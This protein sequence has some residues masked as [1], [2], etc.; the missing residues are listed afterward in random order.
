MSKEETPNTASSQMVFSPSHSSHASHN[1]T[2]LSSTSTVDYPSSNLMSTPNTDGGRLLGAH[3]IGGHDGS[4]L[5]P[6]I[7]AQL[8]SQLLSGAKL[9]VGQR[10]AVCPQSKQTPEQQIREE[11]YLKTIEKQCKQ[12]KQ[13]NEQVKH[14]EAARSPTTSYPM[15]SKPHGLAY[16]FGNENFGRNPSRPNLRLDRRLG[17]DIDVECFVLVFRMLDY[18]ICVRT[19]FT[20]DEIK[21]EVHRIAALDDSAYDS[22]VFCFTT[23]GESNHYIFGSDSHTVDVYHLTTMVQL[24][25]TLENKPKMFFIQACRVEPQDKPNVTSD[26]NPPEILHNPNADL[27]IAWATTRNSPAYRSSTYG[28]WFPVAMYKVFT[29]SANVYNLHTMMLKVNDMICSTKGVDEKAGS[30]AQQCVERN[31]QLRYDIVFFEQ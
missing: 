28:S 2:P 24:C 14:L 5:Q 23:H 11:E 7:T 6:N 27:F 1:I 29:Q 22:V 4:V 9:V 8:S 15:K 16:V 17:T 12:L 26:G 19:D 31:E 30:P 21:R 25:P 10:R 20:A 18:E 3:P 13:L